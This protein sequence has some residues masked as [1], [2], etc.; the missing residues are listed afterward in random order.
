MRF[1]QMGAMATA[2]GMPLPPAAGS[3]PAAGGGAGGAVSTGGYGNHAPVALAVPNLA[4]CTEYVGQPLGQEADVTPLAPPP[5]SQQHFASAGEQIQPAPTGFGTLPTGLAALVNALPKK[6]V[7]GV[8]PAEAARL[9]MRLRC[10][11]DEASALPKASAAL[12]GGAFG[13]AEEGDG[14]N[15]SGAA[16]ASNSTYMARKRQKPA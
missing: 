9:A 16:R 2:N 5:P 14:E 13:A 6:G 4:L 7:A 11:P 8:T 10:M 1:F 3:I 12:G 15:A